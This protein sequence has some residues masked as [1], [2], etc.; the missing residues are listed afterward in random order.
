[1][2]GA[3]DGGGLSLSFWPARISQLDCMKMCDRTDGDLEKS[4]RLSFMDN[5]KCISDIE[6]G[7]VETLGVT[8]RSVSTTP[9][10]TGAA[11]VQT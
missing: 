4:D 7:T 1:M 9:F 2:L 3:R 6:L 11:V 10:R 5:L 8:W